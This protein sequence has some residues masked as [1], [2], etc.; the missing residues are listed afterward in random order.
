MAIVLVTHLVKERTTIA[1][2]SIYVEIT[3]LPGSYV[4][5]EIIAV[6]QPQFLLPSDNLGRSPKFH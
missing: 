2:G 6:R 3:R 4:N 5:H 1:S